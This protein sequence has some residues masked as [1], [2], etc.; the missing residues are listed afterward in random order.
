M[1]E[2][3]YLECINAKVIAFSDTTAQR[4]IISHLQGGGALPILSCTSESE[5]PGQVIVHFQLE[6][7]PGQLLPGSFKATVS[8]TENKVL[9]IEP[10]L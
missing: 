3:T 8:L 1:A 7:L 10:D 4:Y 6:M 9:N 5:T 2:D